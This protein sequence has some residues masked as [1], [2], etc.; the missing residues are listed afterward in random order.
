MAD[1]SKKGYEIFVLA[2]I[3]VGSTGVSV[4]AVTIDWSFPN[5]V[6]VSGDDPSYKKT[7]A[8]VLGS[9]A[10]PNKLVAAYNDAGATGGSNC[11][12][13]TSSDAGASWTVR[14]FP[15]LPTSTNFGTDPVL[16]VNGSGSTWYMICLG[17]TDG[18]YS[19]GDTSSVFYVTSSNNGTTWGSA[20]VL[21]TKTCSS[22]SNCQ[23]EDKPWITAAGNKVYSCWTRFDN[24]IALGNGQ[25]TG[26][27]IIFRKIG[28]AELSPLA[29]GTSNPSNLFVSDRTVQGCTIAVNGNGVIYVAWMRNSEDQH[30]QIQMRR[31]FDNGASFDS[32]QNITTFT[33]LPTSVGNCVN[34]FGCAKG[35]FVQ[36]TQTGFR[37]PG[38]PQLAIDNSNNVNVVYESYTSSS[39]TDISYLKLTN[40]A[41]SGQSCTVSGPV[42][43]LNDG[44]TLKDQFLGSITYSPRT[45]TLHIAALDRRSDTQNVKWQPYDYHCELS[46]NTC[47]SNA[48]W[49]TSNIAGNQP[50][51]NF[52]TVTTPGDQF[53]GDYYRI[54][55]TSARDGHY[56]WVDTRTYN[57]NQQFRIWSDRTS[58]GL[59][60]YAEDCSGNSLNG[61][62]VKLYDSTGTTLLKSGFTPMYV[63]INQTGNYLLKFNNYGNNTFVSAGPLPL[64]VTSYTQ[65]TAW[66]GDVNINLAENR[67]HIVEGKYNAVGGT[68]CATTGTITVKSIRKDT[69]AALTGLFTQLT[70][71]NNNVLATGYTPVTFTESAGTYIVYPNDFGSN[72]FDHWDDNGST[73]R[74][75]TVSLSANQ[76]WEL[77]AVYRVQ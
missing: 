20:N 67:V 6:L 75:R 66:G 3:I 14:S 12:P 28:S 30:G 53:I 37:I 27:H 62:S 59:N 29:N 57:G 34:A 26:A 1:F 73:T 7:E 19:I 32:V 4:Y 68:L 33:R 16:A 21:A 23:L 24:K 65:Y 50:I 8:F 5:D 72:V 40:C 51:N 52:I 48:H 10:D 55:S 15:S 22:S 71:Q 60:A 39:L 9:P 63:K 42:N 44:G 64:P 47:T 46:Q 18:D 11:R 2:I 13:S 35:A 49:S 74:G 76:E 54:A 36:N 56:V 77:T 69:G 31:S 25:T 38:F 61:L 41:T 70:D 45:D 43:V 58:G 17:L